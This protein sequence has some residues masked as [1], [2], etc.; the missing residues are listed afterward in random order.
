MLAGMIRAALTQDSYTELVV[1]SVVD[2]AAAAA[3]TA[4]ITFG[5]AATSAG[6]INL[7]IA[8]RRVRVGVASGAAS[9]AVA[10]SVS[11]AINAS[12]DL[13]VTASVL[14]SV[15]TV[16]ARN[17]GEAA[18]GLD[19]R[20][21]YYVGEETAPGITAAITAMA[22]GVAN[23]DLS[24][25]MA[26]LG[27]TWFHTWA[28]PYTDAANLVI[29]E[30]ELASRFAWDREIEGHA[31]AALNGTQ[32]QLAA[33]GESRNSPHLS[34][35]MSVAE[36]MPAYEKAAETMAI[37]AYYLSIDP[38]RPV[39]TL[40]YKW[41]LPANEADRL[42]KQEQNMLLFDG[43]ATTYVDAG[44]IMRTERLITTYKESANG[45]SDTSYLDVETLF[46]LMYIRHDWR[47]YVKRKYPRHKLADDGTRYGA[48]QAVVT[49][50]VMKAEAVVKA[51]EWET[52]ALVENVDDFK[53]NLVGERNASDPNRLD[54]LLPPNLVNQLRII[55]NKIQFRL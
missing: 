8:G 6:A 50:S 11:A 36:P 2:D 51:R 49:P 34:I 32:G 48:G 53:T 21:N 46:T 15:V 9:A 40:E 12:A 54:M 38:A 33:L 30:G 29:V 31:F 28:I 10:T 16:T 44:G 20:L 18:N 27:D 35:V 19:I 22:G 14:A 24:D 37:G 3:A 7:M 45:A 47:D 17:K 41:C 25:A 43:I 4:T 13:P 39:Q 42:T 1:M 55:A 5:G 23:P 52:L 26:A